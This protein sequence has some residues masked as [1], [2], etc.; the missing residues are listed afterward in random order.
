MTIVPGFA[1]IPRI[2]AL[3]G[4]LV[5]TRATT[6]LQETTLPSSSSH[7]SACGWP[8]VMSLRARKEMKLNQSKSM[9]VYHLHR[10]PLQQPF[11]L[12]L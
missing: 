8:R 2:R 10:A 7:L 12:K 6:G 4:L 3:I 11:E 1:L 5:W 9:R